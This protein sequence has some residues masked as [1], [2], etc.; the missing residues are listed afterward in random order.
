MTI[1]SEIDADS[2]EHVMLSLI[3]AIFL[4][5]VLTSLG[6]YFSKTLTHESFSFLSLSIVLLLWTFKERVIDFIS[7]A[8]LRLFGAGG[9]GYLHL[10]SLWFVDPRELTFIGVATRVVAG[11]YTA[12]L[13]AIFFIPLLF[14]VSTYSL[15]LYDALTPQQQQQQQQQTQEKL[16]H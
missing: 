13:A 8:L 12:I 10:L 1:T 2:P 11:S 6:L 5:Y 16:Q 3:L 9:Q 15:N 7:P 4:F 14:A